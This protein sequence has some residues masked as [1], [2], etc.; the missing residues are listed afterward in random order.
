MEEMPFIPCHCCGGSTEVI[1]CTKCFEL[2]MCLV[3]IESNYGEDHPFLET[4]DNFVCL[5]C[6]PS[7]ISS[8]PVPNFEFEEDEDE[9]ITM[10]EEKIEDLNNKLAAF[11]AELMGTEGRLHPRHLEE[12]LKDIGKEKD[13]EDATEA[14]F[15]LYKTKWENYHR[16]LYFEIC[17]IRELIIEH[18]AIEEAVN[19]PEIRNKHYLPILNDDKMGVGHINEMAKVSNEEFARNQKEEMDENNCQIYS[20][21]DEFEDDNDERKEMSLHHKYRSKIVKCNTMQEFVEK[22]REDENFQQE[23]QDQKELLMEVYDLGDANDEFML[24]PSKLEDLE[25]SIREAVRCEEE[26]RNE[27]KEKM[28]SSSSSSNQDLVGSPIDISDG[29]DRKELTTFEKS[30][31]SKQKEKRMKRRIILHPTTTTTTSSSQNK[32]FLPIHQTPPK[33]PS[34]S[35]SSSSSFSREKIVPPPSVPRDIW[36]KYRDDPVFDLTNDSQDETRDEEEQEEEKETTPSLNLSFQEGEQLDSSSPS[37]RVGSS[38]SPS[39][40]RRKMK[41]LERRANE[42]IELMQSSDEEDDNGNGEHIR[43]GGSSPGGSSR[44]EKSPAKYDKNTN[45]EE[46]DESGEALG[47]L[48]DQNPM[49]KKKTKRKWHSVT[50]L[51]SII[52][53]EEEEE[54]EN[55]TTDLIPIRVSKKLE[56]KRRRKERQKVRKAQGSIQRSNQPRSSSSSS[57]SSKQFPSTIHTVGMTSSTA[58]KKKMRR[59]ERQKARKAQGSSKLHNQPPHQTSSSSSSSS[60]L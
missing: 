14:E 34:S 7:P 39:P 53:E 16:L 27:L 49:K 40:R 15:E 31:I 36:E 51:L 29:E 50:S 46:E 55:E 22:M 5:S 33:P 45:E 42:T 28:T 41:S 8:R 25:G 58:L 43:L 56:K 19:Y 38:Q 30:I 9:E 17:Q 12:V 26:K 1:S 37:Q 35:A 11:E 13:D 48:F 44:S 52:G 59:K 4:T 10:D 32:N 2:T 3:C 6:D 21:F 60:N 57:S 23:S 20:Y 24:H 54:Q 47:F 18:G